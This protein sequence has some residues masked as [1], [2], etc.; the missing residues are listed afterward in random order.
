[1]HQKLDLHEQQNPGCQKCSRHVRKQNIDDGL[2]QQ[3]TSCLDGATLRCVGPWARDKLYFLTQ[4]LGI[5]ADGMKF[6]WQG[7]L[8][9]IELCSGPGRCVDRESGVEMDGTALTVMGHSAFQHIRTATFL[10]YNLN[11]VDALSSRIKSAGYA[12]R[13]CAIKADYNHPENIAEIVGGRVQKG[14]A[15]VF[16]D[17][18]DCSV[19]FDTVATLAHTLPN[20]DFIINVALGTDATRNIK[21][22]ILNK[23]SKAR[24]KYAGFLGGQGF[25]D[26]TEVITM[27]EHGQDDKLR[28]KFREAYRGAMRTLKYEHFDTQCVEHY[29]DLFFACRHPLGLKFWNSAKKYEP[30]NQGTFDFS[31]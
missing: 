11:V 18:T 15:L 26:D 5:F 7:N 10:D 4:Y 30:N 12:D 28:A 19:P 17:P 25:F 29:Y 14:L 3:A 13:A 1:M 21:P 31:L 27:A 23:D 22:A 6:K 9:Y 8:H 2:C 24:I 16:V 20:A